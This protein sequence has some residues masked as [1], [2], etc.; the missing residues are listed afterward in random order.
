MRNKLILEFTEFNAMR[1]NPDSVPQSTHVDNPSL[2]LDGY[3]RFDSNLKN[4][5][6]RL[7][8]IFRDINKTNIAFSLKSGG[9][10]ES[11]DIKN[12]K[13]LR[14][15]PNDDIFYNV[16]FSFDIESEEYYGVIENIDSMNPRLS[17][18][19]FRDIKVQGGVEWVIRIK[20][21]LIKAI[22]S[23]LKPNKGNYLLLK[24][25]DAM[26]NSG[27]LTMIPINSKVKVS[28]SN[29]KEV[30]IIF[31]EKTYTLRG[32]NYIY[33]NYYFKHLGD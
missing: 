22:K 14:I 21:N 3:S 5:L 15:F 4:A 32:R 1:L 8:T 25:I 33:F 18:E 12:I 20:G 26:D 30:F 28:S 27:Q 10:I 17:S 9:V 24:D 29:K 11:S 31:N 19:L 13:I 6:G 7:N 16:Y 2:S 23:W